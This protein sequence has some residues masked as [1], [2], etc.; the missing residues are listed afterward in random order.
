MAIKVKK[1]DTVSVSGYMTR[2]NGKSVVWVNNKN[3]LSNSKIDDVSVRRSAV[4]KDKKVTITVD[5]VKA[6][7]KPGE[8]WYKNSGK[9]VDS[10]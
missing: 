7:I 9:I 3:T 10:Y 2:S 1:S 8:T 6:R 5:G 4:G